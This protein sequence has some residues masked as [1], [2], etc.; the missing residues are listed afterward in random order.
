MIIVA[1][2]AERFGNASENNASS[3][4]VLEIHVHPYQ[5][6]R[7]Y[8]AGVVFESLIPTQFVAISHSDV[9]S[10]QQ[11]FLLHLEIVLNK[12]TSLKKNGS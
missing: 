12:M 9:P 7:Q 11:Y 10:C 5:E 3:N 8:S 1:V 2:S 4:F 6:F